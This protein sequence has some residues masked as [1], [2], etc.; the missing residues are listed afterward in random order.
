MKHPTLTLE[1]VDSKKELESGFYSIS[2]QFAS[3]ILQKRNEDNRPMSEKKLAQNVADIKSGSFQV[4]GE[5]L[6]FDKE[7]KLLDGQHRLQAVLLA[8]QA[9]VSNVC[10]GV[11]PK[12]KMSIDQGKA[13]S[14]GDVLGLH[15]MKN[16]NAVAS[17]ARHVISYYRNDGTTFGRA[18]N[19]TT[20][21]I[22]DEMSRRPT[23]EAA[24]QWAVQFQKLNEGVLTPSQIAI[25][26]M[27]LEPIYGPE[28]TFF[29]ER[30][31][32]GDNIGARHPAFA[33]RKRLRLKKDGK[34]ASNAVV[35]EV[36][37]R[38]F[39]AF[40][41]G[42]ELDHIQLLGQLPKLNKIKREALPPMPTTEALNR[43]KPMELHQPMAS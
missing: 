16:A 37:M 7:G 4:N 12:A 5:T 11:E 21:E 38:G 8:K 40:H 42:R 2:P 24:L 27:I 13:R 30:V 34:R 3:V 33:V 18:G 1:I 41:E 29:L 15:G 28:V 9:I 10:F 35:A 36:L 22:V 31:G 26:Y 20:A 6:I 39:I 23:I 25:V 32:L 43:M 17:V 14:T 19:V